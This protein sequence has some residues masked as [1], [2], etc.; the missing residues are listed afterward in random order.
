MAA[1]IECG[2]I[3]I[4]IGESA[5]TAWTKAKGYHVPIGPTIEGLQIANKIERDARMHALK[6]YH[7]ALAER[8]ML[9]HRCKEQTRQIYA[10]MTGG[11]RLTVSAEDAVSALMARADEDGALHRDA[12]LEVLR[13]MGARHEKGI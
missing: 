9:A 5:N 7:E 6:L 10:L 1:D 12:M 3:G 11:A 2:V 8:D 13:K 4:S